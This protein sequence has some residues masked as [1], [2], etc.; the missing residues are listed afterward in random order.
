MAE[1]LANCVTKKNMG[2]MDFRF[3]TLGNTPPFFFLT[4]FH[5]LFWQKVYNNASD[6]NYFIKKFTNCW[7]DKWLLVNEKVILMV[8]LDENK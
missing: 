5:E 4:K 3:V 1:K 6:T 8:G 2:I 7:C